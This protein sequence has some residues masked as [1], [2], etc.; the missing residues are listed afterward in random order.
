MN[1]FKKTGSQ[2]A[3]IA[4]LCLW[5]IPAHSD[6]GSFSTLSYNVAGLLEVFSS[7]DSDRQEA[8]EQISCY[9]NEFDVVNVQEDFNYHAALY[10]TCNDHPYRSATTGGMGVGSGLNSMSRF[11]YTDWD[12]VDWEACNGV[13]C[14]TPKGFTLARTR[15]AEGVYVDIYNLH[16]QAQTE[17]ADLAARRADILQLIA[18]IETNSAGNAVIVMG[19]TNTRYTRSGDNMWEFLNRGFQD[20]WV[21]LIRAGDVPAGGVDALVCDPKITDADC[22]IV[23]KVV[24]RSNAFIDLSA[25]LYAVR[26]DDLTHDGLKL[27]DHPPVHTR[28]VWNTRSDLSMSDMVGGP[29]GSAFND[30]AMLPANPSVKTVTLRSGTR[31]DN[32]SLTLSQGYVLSHGGSGGTE[33]SLTL[34]TGEYLASLTVCSGQKDGHTRIFSAQFT[35]TQNRTVSGGET[36]SDCTSFHAPSGWQIV[37]FKGRAAD[38]LDKIGVIYAPQTQGDS[39]VNWT[40]LRNNASELCLDIDSANMANGT[41]VMQWHCTGAAWQTWNYDATSGLIRSQHDARYCLDNGGT[42]GNGANLMIWSCNGNANQRFLLNDDG[43]IGMRT[44][45]TQVL[46]GY[47]VAAGDNVGTWWNWGGDNQRWTAVP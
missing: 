16:T 11:E 47:G 26:Q 9:V 31:I 19:D 34:N 5:H 1:V 4:S 42:F 38:E 27:S 40:S 45:S 32:V 13:D 37:G 41:N 2:M 25:V 12:R 22:E 30:V 20:A 23:D 3:V 24:Y 33:S 7:A 10:D 35:T 36:T 44:L 6:S 29:H 8:T 15:L 46:D 17:D 21:D 43:S 39:S 28:F 14:L 18:Y